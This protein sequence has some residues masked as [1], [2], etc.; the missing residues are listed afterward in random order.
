MLNLRLDSETL[1]GLLRVNLLVDAEI[2]RENLERLGLGNNSK[3]TLQ[4]TCHL[5]QIKGL[6]YI[7]HFKEV[8]HILNKEV[9]WSLG[10]IERRNKIARLLNR[11]G[12][13]EVEDPRKLNDSPYGKYQFDYDANV[14]KIKH[15]E[16]LNYELKSKCDT[17]IFARLI[18]LQTQ[19]EQN[20]EK[21]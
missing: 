10:D 16:K 8:F 19:K 14:Y 11:W 6:W 5:Q 15:I 2:I 3:K 20:E 1:N 4:Q 17:D 21:E 9:F 18:E 12:L 13:L 7:L